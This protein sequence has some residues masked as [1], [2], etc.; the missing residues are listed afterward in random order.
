MIEILSRSTI[1]KLILSK[2]LDNISDTDYVV[3]SVSTVETGLEPICEKHPDFDTEF[4][5]IG[6]LEE[7]K[8]EKMKAFLTLNFLDTIPS[9]FDTGSIYL[10]YLFTEQHADKVSSFVNKYKDLN[11]IIHCTAGISRSAAIAD[12]V[13]IIKNEHDLLWRSYGGRIKPNVWV[14]SLLKRRL[15]NV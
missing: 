9:K 8:S 12:Y 10:D 5:M 15:W 7:Y 14:Q 3:I 6:L 4:E 11:F 2:E 1:I 13:S